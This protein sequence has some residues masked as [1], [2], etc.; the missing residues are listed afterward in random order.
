MAGVLIRREIQ[1]QTHKEK[2]H[3]HVT[4]KVEIRTMLPSA[5]GCQGF[6]ATTRSKEKARKGSPESL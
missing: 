3:Y 1:R 6:L 2:E 4:I 5:K